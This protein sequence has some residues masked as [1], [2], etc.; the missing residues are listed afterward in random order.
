MWRK[1]IYSL[2]TRLLNCDNY[3]VLNVLSIVMH[4]SVIFKHWNNVLYTC[5]FNPTCTCIYFLMS[6]A[7]IVQFYIDLVSEIKSIHPSIKPA[8]SD[9]VNF[10]RCRL[11]TRIC[12]DLYLAQL[13]NAKTMCCSCHT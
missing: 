1:L 2:R 6:Y 10:Q 13:K 5:T 8:V 11:S 3:L 7:L 4:E 9:G 12:A